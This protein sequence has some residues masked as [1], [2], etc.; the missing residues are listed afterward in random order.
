MPSGNGK[1]G[2][3]RDVTFL[4]ARSVTIGKTPNSRETMWRL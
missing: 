4:E 3:E 1:L 2:F